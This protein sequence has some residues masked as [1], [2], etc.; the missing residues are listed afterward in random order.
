MDGSVLMEAWKTPRFARYFSAIVAAIGIDSCH[1]AWAR[2]R[3]KALSPLA[4]WVQKD[5]DGS[6]DRM[7]VS[8]HRPRKRSAAI[9]CI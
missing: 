9:T 4:E 7:F 3:F 1:N 2:R 5:A 8:S 6:L